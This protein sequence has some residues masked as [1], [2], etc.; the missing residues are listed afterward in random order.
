MYKFIK[1]KIKGK[2]DSIFIPILFIIF[3]INKI[4][5][6]K[7]ILSN[8]QEKGY[9][10]SPKYIV[11]E[12]LKNNNDYD[13]VWITNEVDSLPSNIRAVKPY[14]VKCIYELSTAKIWINNTRCK[15]YLRKRKEQKYI[16]T[17]HGGLALKKIEYDAESKLSNFY[18][19]IIKNDNRMIDYLISNSK[20]CT[21]MYRSAFKYNGEILEIG[22]PR[23]DV[24][25]NSLQESRKKVLEFY[26]ISKEEKILLY[27]P[28]FRNNYKLNPYDVDFVNLKKS[29]EK[30]G[31]KWRILIRLHPIIKDVNKV[32][33]VCGEYINVSS[34]PDIQELISSCD[35]LITDY[36]S[37]M[38]EAMIANKPV[39]LY[40]NDLNLYNNERG[41]Y[42]SFDE[43]PF[44]LT[45]NNQELIKLVN[46]TNFDDLK[47]NYSKFKEKVGLFEKGNASKKVY[48]LIEEII[49]KNS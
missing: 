47:K 34:Y 9:G 26:N 33:K 15:I 43:L 22:T 7:I 2:I 31:D 8:F 38:F 37:T 5:N 6:K 40:A 25:I 12:I 29:L 48:E 4:N 32:I 19:K 39:I 49:N 16:Q 27:A 21:N 14:T 3:R 41:F 45:Q 30:K 1:S 18:K 20:F 35:L 13:I 44:E 36:S 24:F 11:E 10:D 46:N 28:T 17:W 42:F 23:N